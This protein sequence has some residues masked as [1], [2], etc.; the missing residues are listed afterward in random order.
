MKN[1]KCNNCGASVDV[2][3]GEKCKY[4]GSVFVKPE[5]DRPIVINNYYTVE[6]KEVQSSAQNRSNDGYNKYVE[7]ET[8]LEKLDPEINLVLCV[9][10]FVISPFIGVV[11]L[12]YKI[13]KAHKRRYRDD[14]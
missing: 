6:K 5:D 14:E 1:R 9:F 4:C 7:D 11:Y 12:L 10:L 8:E 13:N 3:V 2:E